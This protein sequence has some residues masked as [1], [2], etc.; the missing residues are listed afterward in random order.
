MGENLVA[1]I[2]QRIEKMASVNKDTN[3]NILTSVNKTNTLLSKEIGSELRKQTSLLENILGSLSPA[4]VTIL[5]NKNDSL[6]ASL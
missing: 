5:I 1:G 3:V 4:S 2:L 6:L